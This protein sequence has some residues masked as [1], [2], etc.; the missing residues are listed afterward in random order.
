MGVTFLGGLLYEVL[1]CVDLVDYCCMEL[2]LG[3]LI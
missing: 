3:P 1:F 2:V